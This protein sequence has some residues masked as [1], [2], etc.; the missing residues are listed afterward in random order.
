M[1]SLHPYQQNLIE[2]QTKEMHRRPSQSLEVSIKAYLKKILDSTGI[3]SQEI[4]ISIVK[5]LQIRLRL[6]RK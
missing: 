5:C 6:K 1:E 2:M 4:M 3:T